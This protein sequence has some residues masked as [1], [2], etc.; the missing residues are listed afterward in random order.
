MVV[1]EKCIGTL[2]IC[3]LPSNNC[4]LHIRRGMGAEK[5]LVLVT[6]GWGFKEFFAIYILL[7]F[8]SYDLQNCD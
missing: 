7:L 3:W 4:K 6:G 1:R 2:W 8:A 5:K